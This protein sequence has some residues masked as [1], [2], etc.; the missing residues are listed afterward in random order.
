MLV[1]EYLVFKNEEKNK[2]GK[3]TDPAVVVV[4]RQT[5]LAKDEG[6]A[7]LIAARAIPAEHME[8]LDRLVIVCR[9]F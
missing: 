9:P 8:A 2:D 3:V 6:Q 7:N 5:I 1:Y 4:D